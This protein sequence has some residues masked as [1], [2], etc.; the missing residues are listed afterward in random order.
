[1]KKGAGAQT[2]LERAKTSQVHIDRIRAILKTDE[3]ES[4]NDM[5]T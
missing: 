4:G 2:A 1:M 3:N 5:P